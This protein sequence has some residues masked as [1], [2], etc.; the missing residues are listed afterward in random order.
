MSVDGAAPGAERGPLGGV[1]G[2]VWGAG[3]EG[4]VAHCCGAV[5]G[6]GEEGDGGVEVVDEGEE[7][8]AAFFF[9]FL[10]SGGS[11]LWLEQSFGGFFFGGGGGYMMTVMAMVSVL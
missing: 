5:V 3:A 6:W 7:D 9:F 1:E 8:E 11:T 2:G 4:L 10:V